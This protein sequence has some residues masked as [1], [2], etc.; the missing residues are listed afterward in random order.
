MKHSFP[1]RLFP[2]TFIQVVPSP[3]PLSFPPQSKWIVVISPT[4]KK[5]SC[6]FPYRD[7]HFPNKVNIPVLALSSHEHIKVVCL[8][9][10]NMVTV[11][12]IKCLWVSVAKNRIGLDCLAP[13]ECKK[14]I[15]VW[16]LLFVLG[17]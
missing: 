8:L 3:K 6:H 14:Q 13:L 2:H 7:S 1:P 16:P 15:H 9:S 10:C 4:V 12:Y 5:D 11:R 17:N